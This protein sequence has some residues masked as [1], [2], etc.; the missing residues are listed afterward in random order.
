MA[1]IVL[2][3]DIGIPLTNEQM[4]SNFRNLN[5]AIMA[6]IM[7]A[8]NAESNITLIPGPPGPQGPPGPIGPGAPS[9]AVLTAGDQSV[10]GIKSFTSAINTNGITSTSTLEFV[11]RAYSH[12]QIRIRDASAATISF[13]DNTDPDAAIYN[14]TTSMDGG[15][16]SWHFS[17]V[18]T[19]YAYNTSLAPMT[20]TTS[21]VT[22]KMV[23]DYQGN[24]TIAGTLTQ[25]GNSSNSSLAASG[26]EKFPSGLIIQW[27][28]CLASGVVTFPI[29]FPNA[30]FSVAGS[31]YGWFTY[32]GN[33]WA[34]T[35]SLMAS[36]LTPT[37]F[38]NNNPSNGPNN[39][40]HYIAIGN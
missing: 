6:E 32:P 12:P 16:I 21:A 24:L 11:G 10:A 33:P 23:L 22:A 1:T 20:T 40:Q 17:T 7:R 15:V 30:C 34:T 5:N 18:N 39:L 26:Y 2:R 14:Y 19:P 25:G 35:V 13:Y 27:G 38:T 37:G 29:A 3:A 31:G 28:S 36:D 4:D 8:T 9:N